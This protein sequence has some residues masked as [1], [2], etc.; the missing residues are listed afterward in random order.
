MWQVVVV[1]VALGGGG[2]REGSVVFGHS[3]VPSHVPRHLFVTA[4][5]GTL[6]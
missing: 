3:A 6:T 4:I 5:T 2:G 1:V